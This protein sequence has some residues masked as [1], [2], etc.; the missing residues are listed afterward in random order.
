MPAAHPY[1]QDQLLTKLF[2]NVTTRSNVFAVFLTVGFFEVTDSST[3]PVKLGAE[4]GKSENRQVRHKMFAI[5]DRTSLATEFS[6]PSAISPPPAFV[7]GTTYAASTRPADAGLNRYLIS[8]PSGQYP[9]V[10]PPGLDGPV[11]GMSGMYDGIPWSIQ[12]QQP[13]PQ[14]VLGTNVIIDTGSNQEMVNVF[15]VNAPAAANQPATITIS[16]P[17]KAHTGPLAITPVNTVTSYTAIA[18]A[19]PYTLQASQTSGVFEGQN[20]S[21][22]VGTK[23]LIDAGLPKQEVGVIMTNDPNNGITFQCATSPTG[24]FANPHAVP[25]TISYPIPMLGNPGPQATFNY[26]QVPWVVRYFSIVN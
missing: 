19:P 26:R 12:S 5:I 18:G 11:A 24:Q 21:F 16:N 10:P 1:L 7:N 2:N 3:R 6:N 13:G 9:T 17:Q 25:Y 22:Q 14:P 20:W 8:V 15:S 23:F 4:L